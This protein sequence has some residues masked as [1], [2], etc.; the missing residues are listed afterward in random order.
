M[1]KRQIVSSY[2][3][4]IS[5]AL[6]SLLVNSRKNGIESIE[7]LERMPVT[8]SKRLS[9]SKSFCEIPKPESRNLPEF[10]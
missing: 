5:T 7:V 3:I 8:V 2:T 1:T 4:A 9:P 10:E 6:N